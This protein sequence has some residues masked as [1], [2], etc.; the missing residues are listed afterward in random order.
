[1]ARRERQ[2]DGDVVKYDPRSNLIP[3]NKGKAAIPAIP[4]EGIEHL[5]ELFAKQLYAIMM[6]PT[7]LAYFKRLL[8]SDNEKIRAETWQLAFT[9]GWPIPKDGGQGGSRVTIK[10]LIARPGDKD[11]AATEVTVG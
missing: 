5:R 9:H 3:G 6:Q 10:N 4:S 7:T 1:M 2:A 11:V 8:R